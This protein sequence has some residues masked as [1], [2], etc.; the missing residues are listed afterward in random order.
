MELSD[1][2]WQCERY[3]PEGNGVKVIFRNQRTGSIYRK[4]YAISFQWIDGP[5]FGEPPSYFDD[6][7]K[8]YDL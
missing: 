5:L 2:D 4:H 6:L 8:L 1:A 3:E 7:K